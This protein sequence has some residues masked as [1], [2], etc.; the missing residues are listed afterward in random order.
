MKWFNPLPCTNAHRDPFVADRADF[1]CFQDWDVVSGRRVGDW[2]TEVTF[3]AEAAENDGVP[4][5]VL[6]TCVVA[7]PV[8]SE[9]L[10]RS[11]EDADIGGIQY[12][13]VR[14]RRPNGELIPGYS[15]AN[16]LS[17]IPALDDKKSLVTRFDDSR[18]D[19]VGQISGIMKP[20]LRTM[21]LAGMDI[22]RLEEFPLCYYVSD[23]FRR[24]FMEGRFTGYTFREVPLS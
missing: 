22:I 4:D 11:L 24:V 20:T 13:P 21:A 3:W 1:L 7:L 10:R 5:D 9:A 2:S 23:R 14:V 16:I 12:L 15:I 19:R 8:F 18:P 6:Q 17:L